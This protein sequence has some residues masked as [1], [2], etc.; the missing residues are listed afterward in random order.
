MSGYKELIAQT[1]LEYRHVKTGKFVQVE[2]GEVVDGLN[3]V[4]QSNELAAG[5]VKWKEEGEKK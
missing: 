3:E 5:N 2:A 1:H 4:A